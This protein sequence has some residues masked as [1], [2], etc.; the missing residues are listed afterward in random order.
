MMAKMMQ[1]K[2][3]E[4]G[5]FQSLC[6][7]LSEGSLQMSAYLKSFLKKKKKMTN[8]F[9]IFQHEGSWRSEKAQ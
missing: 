8:M 4:S 6:S 9:C 3:L 7:L 5:P 2:V 1:E